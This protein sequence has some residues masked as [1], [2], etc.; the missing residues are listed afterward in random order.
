MFTGGSSWLPALLRLTSLAC[1][2]AMAM[3]VRLASREAPLGQI[4]FF[5]GFFAML[6]LVSYVFWQGGFCKGFT[7]A[8]LRLHLIR[9]CVGA[10]ALV[11]AFA[12]YAYL[13]LAEATLF[14]FLTPIASLIVSAMAL[15]ERP[16][17][18]T[19]VS[20][21]MGITGVSIA[22]SGQLLHAGG[23]TVEIV[24]M[25]CG[26]AGAVLSAGAYVLIRKLTAVEMP[27]RIGF[28]FAVV[29]TLLAAPTSVWGWTA[30]SVNLWCL[31]AGAGIL[32]G[33]G[34]IAMT[35]AFARASVS[36]LA[37]YEYTS[38]FWSLFLDAAILGTTPTPATLTGGLFIVVA[39]ALASSAGQA[40]ATPVSATRPVRRSP[41]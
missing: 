23:I 11:C 12:S 31:L 22:L 38:L 19:V 26:I 5:R 18:V 2:A 39:A 1:F 6:P 14:T 40:G 17:P 41:Q 7:L 36:S 4:V 32:G 9:G 27:S 16:S 3:C 13:P 20:V 37:P 8:I 25:A 29:L 10:T 30:P 24:G 21:L 35:E 34:H 15:G 33:I 28:Y